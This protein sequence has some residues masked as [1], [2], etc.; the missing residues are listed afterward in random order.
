MARKGDQDRIPNEVLWKHLENRT[1]LSD[2]AWLL[3]V[4]AGML[5]GRTDRVLEEDRKRGVPPPFMKPWGDNGPVRYE[6]GDVRAIVLNQRKFNSTLEATIALTFSDFLDTAG[7]NDTWPF[8]IHKGTPID[9]F[10]SLGMGDALTDEDQAVMLTLDEYLTQ[11]REAAWAKEAAREREDVRTFAD[12]ETP[13][14]LPSL[15]DLK[16]DGGRL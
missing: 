15:K 4:Q 9:F 6:M 13:Q 10:K 2:K 14:D 11:R 7:P 5:M 12:A 8:L 16:P 1:E 3:P